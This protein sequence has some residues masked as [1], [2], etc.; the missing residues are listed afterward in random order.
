MK[1]GVR[2]MVLEHLARFMVEP[3]RIHRALV[4]ALGMRGYAIDYRNEVP[5]PVQTERRP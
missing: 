1:G 2:R 5:A 3:N 4:P